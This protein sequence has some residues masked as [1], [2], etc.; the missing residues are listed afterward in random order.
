MKN[1][2]LALGL[3]AFTPP[4]LAQI[5]TN[6]YAVTSIGTAAQRNPSVLQLILPSGQMQQIRTLEAPDGATIFD[7]LGHNSSDPSSLFAMNAILATP[8]SAPNLYRIDRESGLTTVLGDIETPPAPFGSI[9]TA[10]NFIAAGGDNSDYYI[11]GLAVSVRFELDFSVFPPVLRPV[12]SNP[13]FYVG[14]LELNSPNPTNAIWRLADTSDPAAAAI[15]NNY[16]T[17][18]NANPANPNLS[19][20]PRDWVFVRENGAPTLKSYLGVEG[21][22]LTVSNIRSA[23]VVRVTTPAVPLPVSAELG[24]MFSGENNTLYAINTDGGP[25]AGEIYQIDATTGNYLNVTLNSGVGLFR[26]DATTILP[27]RPLP[28]TLTSFEARAERASVALR[29]ATATEEGTDNFRVERSTDNGQTWA[30]IG[31]VKAKNAP[32][33]RTYSFVDDAPQTGL[34]Y[35]RLAILDFDGSLAFSPVRS[36]DFRAA[37][38]TISVYPN[39]AQD[40]FAVELPQLAAPGSTLQVH[41]SLGQQI[42]TQR[43]EGQRTVRVNTQSWAAGVYHLK[44]STNGRSEAQKLVIQP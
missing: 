8:L 39:P 22:L 35:Y 24:A 16:L 5:P 20:G 43:L 36:V 15:I 10:F 28:V 30:A 32:Q 6:S 23:P 7:G 25:N 9:S 2:L 29:W 4:L 27:N 18:I 34:N 42:W 40:Y 41:N 37:Q 38:Q 33:G 12:L 3:L 17:A 1:V 21:Q 13:R 14:E 31:S 26:G 44:V 11:A 19:G